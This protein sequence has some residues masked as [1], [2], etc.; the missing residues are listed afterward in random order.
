MNRIQSKNQRIGTYEI[1]KKSFSLISKFI[2]QNS[3]FKANFI[4][5]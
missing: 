3:F 1:K 2:N 4:L 5:C